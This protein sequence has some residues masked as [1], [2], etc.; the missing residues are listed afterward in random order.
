M[1]TKKPIKDWPFFLTYYKPQED[2]PRKTPELT[3]QLMRKKFIIPMGIAQYLEKR[4]GSESVELIENEYVRQVKFFAENTESVLSLLY[5]DLRRE[6]QRVTILAVIT[7]LED[8]M[9]EG[10]QKIVDEKRMDL[11]RLKTEAMDAELFGE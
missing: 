10:W 7:R 8:E 1:I 11:D 3:G 6:V 9:P 4:L 5:G 2:R